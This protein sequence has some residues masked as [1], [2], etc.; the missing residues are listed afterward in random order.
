MRDAGR[1]VRSVSAARLSVM[2]SGR[3]YVGMLD[4]LLYLEGVSAS[5]TP[6]GLGGGERRARAL[7]DQGRRDRGGCGRTVGCREL[8]AG[9]AELSDCMA[10]HAQTDR[11]ARCA[12]AARTAPQLRCRA[13]GPDAVGRARSWLDGSRGADGRHLRRCGLA[14]VG[15]DVLR[16][17]LMRRRCGLSRRVAMRRVTSPEP[18]GPVPGVVRPR[19]AA[20]AGKKGRGPAGRRARQRA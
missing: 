19:T 15:P 12:L 3:S 20:S 11:V 1:V 14:S 9:D 7:D 5:G 17:R 18:A 10:A 4:T 13:F 8:R 2:R 6:G 16:A